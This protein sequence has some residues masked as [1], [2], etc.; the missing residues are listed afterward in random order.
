MKQKDEGRRMKDEKSPDSSLIPHPSSFNKY[1]TTVTYL[2]SLQKHGIKLGLA[3]TV[4]LMEI[5]GEPHKAFRSVHIAGTNGK[6]STSAAVASILSANGFRVGL[7][8][9][10]H[11]VSFTERMR[12]NNE[13][14]EESEVISIASLIRD[15]M[16]GADL[17]PT[18]FE[19]VTA[20]AFYYFAKNNVDWAVIETGMGGRL[21]ATNVILPEASVITSISLDHCE[22]LGNGI[23]DITFE[24]AGIIKPGIPVITSSLMPDVVRQLSDLAGSRHSEIHVYGK[25]FKGSSL[26]M[27]ERWINFDYSGYGNYNNFSMPLPGKYQLYNACAAVRTIEVLREKGFPVSDDSIRNGLLNVKLEG[28]LEWIS[29]SPPVIIDGAHNPEAACLLADS[30]KELFPDRKIILIAGIMDDKDVGGVLSPL[31]QIAEAVILTKPRYDRAASPEKLESCIM[32]LRESGVNVT[33]SIMKTDTVA[34]ALELARRQC[35]KDSVILVT[36]SFYTTG[37]VKEI[38][39]C[40]GVLTTLREQVRSKK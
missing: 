36:G 20:M 25:D 31:V 27:D 37:E 3:N 35:G 14:I 38:F 1:D 33:A 7:F 2:Y 15:S 13:H 22:F 5:L 11:L 6:G 30:V 19:F 12:I 26:S 8:T 4:K 16:S 39:G 23:S 34:G 24:K 29:E 9:S 18:F 40:K 10:P 21:D 28:R 32:S 17:N